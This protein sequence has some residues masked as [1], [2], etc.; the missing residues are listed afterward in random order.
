[1]QESRAIRHSISE[2]QTSFVDPSG[3]ESPVL[4]YVGSDRNIQLISEKR[5][6]GVMVA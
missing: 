4:G 6:F 1:M 3:Y 2:F 5:L